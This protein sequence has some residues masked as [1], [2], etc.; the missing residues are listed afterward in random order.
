MFGWLVNSS[1]GKKSASV[2]TVRTDSERIQMIIQ[3]DNIR[4]Q[5][6]NQHLKKSL[7]N[8]SR[9]NQDL[10]RDFIKRS[11]VYE[12]KIENLREELE[13]LE[14][15]YSKSQQRLNSSSP[16][17][18]ED[19]FKNLKREEAYQKERLKEEY[20][21]KQ[22]FISVSNSKEKKLEIFSFHHSILSS[23]NPNLEKELSIYKQ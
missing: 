21:S 19:E 15:K 18:K 17:F 10:N 14:E 12:G 1:F 23:F 4:L 22:N 13:F 20:L 11:R 3:S 7:E 8:L 5:R 16:L 9:A 2:Q 6:E